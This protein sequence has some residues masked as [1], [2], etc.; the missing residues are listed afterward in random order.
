M[1]QTQSFQQSTGQPFQKT[2]IID[3]SIAAQVT[4]RDNRPVCKLGWLI[5]LGIIRVDADPDNRMLRRRRFD[6]DAAHLLAV[7]INIVRWMHGYFVT[8][9]QFFTDGIGNDGGDF[10]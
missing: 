7:N 5:N 1:R 3:R 2:A 10:C 6:Q 8:D 9:R 4:E